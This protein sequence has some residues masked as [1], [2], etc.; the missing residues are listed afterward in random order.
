MTFVIPTIG[1]KKILQ[2][3]RNDF[4]GNIYVTKNINLDSEGYI[5]LSSGVAAS[6]TEDDNGDFDDVDAMFIGDAALFVAA[7]EVFR[8]NDIGISDLSSL[9]SETNSPSPGPEDDIIYFNGSQVASDGT[10]VKYRVGSAWTTITTL[11]ISGSHP[12]ALALFDGQ[13]GLMVG[14]GNRVDLVNS[15][16]GLDETLILPTQYK[17]SSMTANGSVAYIGTRHDASGEARMFI[18]DGNSGAASSSFGIG[19][20]EIAALR[21]YESSVLAIS[22]D[23]R[24]LRFT[25]GGFE[26]LAIWPVYATPFDWGNDANDYS[27]AGNRGLV[28]DGSL[29]YA[30]VSS[31]ITSRWKQHLAHMPGGVWCYDPA[32][33]LYHRYATSYT[34]IRVAVNVSNIDLA[35][36]TFTI[37][38]APITGTPVRYNP[39]GVVGITGLEL[40]KTY[41][42]INVSATEFKIAASLKDA[43]AGTE[44]DIPDVGVITQDFIFYEVKDY[45]QTYNS[46]RNSIAIM[47]D[48]MRD[49]RYSE[50]IVWAGPV[51]NGALA[52]INV[53][54][55]GVPGLPNRGY[56]ITPKLFS[57]NKQDTFQSVSYKHAPLSDDD[58]IVV[59][60]K[61]IETRGFPIEIE[62]R[63]DGSIA[64]QEA[65]TWTDTQTFTTDKNLSLVEEGDEIEFVSGIGAGFIAHVSS[66]SESGGTYTVG[67]DEEFL[68]ATNGDKMYFV[69]DRWEKLGEITKENGVCEFRIDEVSD[70]V[71]IKTELIGSEVTIYEMQVGNEKFETAG[72]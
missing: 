66:I 32:V 15:S 20:F 59:K 4:S 3:N 14:H 6:F 23:G 30:V 22:V 17:V 42:A 45:G 68:F 5:K 54:N 72:D 11:T 38:T 44:I 41:F 39:D 69:V 57:A 64:A 46:D 35:T 1:E 56:F 40:M 58:R 19:S 50:R 49:D 9:A 67:L 61:K 51:D 33:G 28:V 7:D 25:G 13:N 55:H 24:L 29:A 71:Q 8:G 37:S 48:T 12:T 31:E 70:F 47:S 27:A 18:W 52:E 10:T 62:D 63:I 21:T 2:T 65:G 60:Y 43:L 53:L 34:N 36:N 16:W 26:E